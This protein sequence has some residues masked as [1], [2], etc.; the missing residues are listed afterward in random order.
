MEGEGLSHGI[1]LFNRSEYFEAHEVLEDVWRDAPAERK[2]FLQGL[3]QC[4]VA[5]HHYSTGNRVGMRG[6]MER[7]I[8]NL[9]ECPA[10][11]RVVEVEM[12]VGSLMRWREALD[13][14]NELPPLPKIEI[15]AS[16]L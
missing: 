6:V 12:L 10:D 9:G 2:R 1:A 14:G 15:A 16:G 7:A 5:F 13:N 11:F 3:V 8:R 4:A